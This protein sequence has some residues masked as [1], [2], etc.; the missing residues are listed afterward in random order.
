[1]LLMYGATQSRAACQKWR[2]L[3][4]TIHTEC[5][6]KWYNTIYLFIY[7]CQPHCRVLP[8]DLIPL[9]I[10]PESFMATVVTVFMN[11]CYGNRH[12]NKATL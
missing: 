12:H 4:D 6:K 3:N 8:S 11:C 7:W 5:T 10:Y 9:Q 2:R 1:M